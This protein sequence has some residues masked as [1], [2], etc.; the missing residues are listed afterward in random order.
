[1]NAELARLALACDLAASCN[2]ALR[3]ALGLACVERVRHLLEEPGAVECLD[4]LRAFMQGRA[5]P[6]ERALAGKALEAA[7]YAA[8]ATV[9]AYGSYAVNDPSAFE[10]EFAWQVECLEALSQPQAVQR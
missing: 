3:L 7:S 5:S 9:Y 8:Y 10:A 6:A 2:E 1:M 4:V